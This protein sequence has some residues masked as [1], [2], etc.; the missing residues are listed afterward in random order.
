ME[1]H[2][3]GVRGGGGQRKVLP[4]LVSKTYLRYIV[5]CNICILWLVLLTQTAS[6]R[7]IS[8]KFSIGISLFTETGMMCSFVKIS[9]ASMMI[10]FSDIM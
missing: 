2:G 10:F 9:V 1:N 6:R 7:C 5:E 8:K 4:K 3:V